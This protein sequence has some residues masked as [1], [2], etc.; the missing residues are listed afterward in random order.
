MYGAH[1]RVAQLRRGGAAAEKHTANTPCDSFVNT[2]MGTQTDVYTQRN[3]QVRCGASSCQS[4]AAG[5]VYPL[6]STMRRSCL[7]VP[8]ASEPSRNSQMTTPAAPITTTTTTAPSTQAQVGDAALLQA[9]LSQSSQHHKETA[10]ALSSL[11]QFLQHQEKHLVANSHSLS[12]LS[13]LVESHQAQVTALQGL[14]TEI[15]AMATAIRDAATI[16]HGAQRVEEHP[17][18]DGLPIHNRSCLRRSAASAAPSSSTDGLVLGADSP[19]LTPCKRGGEKKEEEMI[20][21]RGGAAY[22]CDSQRPHVTLRGT[23]GAARCAVGS[24][25]MEDDIFSM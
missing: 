17:N 11:V 6:P 19:P 7:A 9:T 13:A 22:V 12:H 23:A 3:T 1:H 10:L 15:R 2:P 4:V 20:A 21:K 14:T 16:L 8:H 24:E 25:F 18:L 5:N